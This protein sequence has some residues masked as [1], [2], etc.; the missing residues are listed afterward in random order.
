MINV[1]KVSVF[2]VFVIFVLLVKFFKFGFLVKKLVLFVLLLMN[3]ENI[4]VIFEK[5]FLWM[6]VNICFCNVWEVILRRK[7]LGSKVIMLDK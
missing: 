6:F 1:D 3:K 4:G 5:V 2:K 7:L